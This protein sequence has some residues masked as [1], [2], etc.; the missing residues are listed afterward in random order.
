MDKRNE[1]Y[2]I[3]ESRLK[4]YRGM[5][6]AVGIRCRER[7]EIVQSLE[8]A[9]SPSVARYDVVGGRSSNALTGPEAY[10]E[11]TALLEKR[12]VGHKPGYRS[13]GRKDSFADLGSIDAEA[14]RPGDHRGVLL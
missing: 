3:T 13:A 10:V 4:D 5:Q 2:L 1:F 7:S 8:S 6:A 11:R 9:A 14:R 12:S